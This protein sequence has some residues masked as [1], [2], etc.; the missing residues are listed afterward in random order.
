M[1]LALGLMPL[2]SQVYFLHVATLALIYSVFALGLQLLTGHAGQLSLGQAAFFGAGAYASALLSIR[3]GLSF[4]I[5]APTAAVTAALLG[6]CLAPITRLRG[7]YLAVATLGF[8]EIVHLV[9]LNWVELTRG[10]FGLLD[11]PTGPGRAGT[12]DPFQ[13]YYLALGA[14]AAAYVFVQLITAPSSRFG[15]GSGQLLRTSW[16]R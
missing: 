10:P 9:L 4:W 14:A 6:A 5:A 8:G 7:H 11:V 13:Y 16:P 1:L 15:R 2:L 12:Y 3:L